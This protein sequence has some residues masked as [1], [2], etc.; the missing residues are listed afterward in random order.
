[1][2]PICGAMPNCLAPASHLLPVRNSKPY[3]WMAG[4]AVMAICTTSATTTPMDARAMRWV[5]RRNDQSK[6]RSS[7]VGG[8][9]MVSGDVSGMVACA[10]NARSRNRMLR[11]AARGQWTWILRT[12]ARASF[13]A[14]SGSGT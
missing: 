13:R 2:P 7:P 4:D 1:M 9:K 8:R 12:A 11:A 5:S 3:S 10:M 14:C 6:P